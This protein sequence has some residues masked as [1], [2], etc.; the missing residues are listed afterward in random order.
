MIET[1]CVYRG[2]PAKRTYERRTIPPNQWY[3][4][5]LP[6]NAVKWK[7]A[8]QSSTL[9]MDVSFEK[10]PPDNNPDFIQI[11]RLGLSDNFIDED[12]IFPSKLWIRFVG[13]GNQTYYFEFIKYD[14]DG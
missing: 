4:I 11:P 9:S 8:N 2:K 6:V 10:Q 3:E 14:V 13:A 12:Q 1:D 7:I 5:P